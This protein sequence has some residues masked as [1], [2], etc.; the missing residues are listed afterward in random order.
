MGVFSH[1]FGK[2]AAFNTAIDNTIGREFGVKLVSSAKMQNALTMWDNISKG[3]PSWVSSEDR[4][5]TINMAKPLTSIYHKIQPCLPRSNIFRTYIS[6]YN[7]PSH[8][9]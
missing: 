7:L 1:L 4:I 3:A 8:S 6:A 9:L 5:K 2:R